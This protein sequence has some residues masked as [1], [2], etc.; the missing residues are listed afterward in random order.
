MNRFSG[1]W[2]VGWLAVVVGLSACETVEA[3]YIDKN[4]PLTCEDTLGATGA[5]DSQRRVL[6][7]EYTGFLCGNCPAAHRTAQELKGQYGERLITVSVHAGVLAQPDAQYPT[8]YRTTTGN[9]LDNTFGISQQGVPRGMVNRAPF[10]GVVG[11]KRERWQQ[12]IDEQLA[13]APGVELRLTHR[14]AP[15]SRRVL[16]RLDVRYPRAQPSAEDLLTVYVVED[17]VVGVQKQY[18]PDTTYQAYPHR[19]MLRGTLNGTFGQSLDSP[20]G[21]GIPAGAVLTRYLCGTL[22]PAWNP[23][24][25]YL[26]AVVTDKSTRAVRQVRQ[27]RLGS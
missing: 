11:L 10:Q 7:E 22:D 15:E 5:F 26:V 17:S 8:D 6:L 20:G 4:A 27:V 16:V 18:N 1:W 13:Q 21:G 12:A 14:F 19:Y 23:D 2:V 9:E 25:M 3:P 24:H